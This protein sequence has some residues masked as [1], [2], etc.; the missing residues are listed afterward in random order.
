MSGYLKVRV[1][2]IDDRELEKY[3][4][5]RFDEYTNSLWYYGSWASKDKAEDVAR[6]IGNG[7]VVENG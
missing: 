4:V 5:A 6:Q 7:V 2:N 1:E 3:V